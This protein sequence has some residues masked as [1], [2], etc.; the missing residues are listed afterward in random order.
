MIPI[1][2]DI[3]DAVSVIVQIIIYLCTWQADFDIILLLSSVY[4][5]KNRETSVLG[6][7]INNVPFQFYIDA[8][9][10]LHC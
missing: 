7:K 6:D 8:I 2:T 3:I 9:K 1:T 4:Q 10:I 5:I